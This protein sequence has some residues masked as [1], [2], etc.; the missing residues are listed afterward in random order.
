MSDD[1]YLKYLERCLGKS[2]D[3]C[4]IVALS[5]GEVV[6]AMWPLNDRFKPYLHRI[7]A[8]PYDARFEREADDV[9]EALV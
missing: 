3:G 2:P 9:I 7:A 8:L 1:L 5:G 4:E 6:E